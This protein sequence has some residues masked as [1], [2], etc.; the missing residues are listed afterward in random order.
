MARSTRLSDARV[1][2]GGEHLKNTSSDI[3][4]RRVQHRVVISE[5]DVLENHLGVVF[6]EAAPAAVF[7]LHGEEPVDGAQGNLMLVALARVVDAIESQQHLGGVVGVG[8]KLVVEFEVPA[9]GLGVC[10]L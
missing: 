9:A 1:A 4:S 10:A 8:V 3:N 7:A 5:R 6:V 2:V